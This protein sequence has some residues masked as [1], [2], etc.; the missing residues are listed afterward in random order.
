LNF[1][2]H[3][4]DKTDKELVLFVESSHVCPYVFVKSTCITGSISA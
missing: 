4:N 1:V 2:L 3:I